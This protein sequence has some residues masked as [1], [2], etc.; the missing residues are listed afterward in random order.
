MV[1]ISN[2][3]TS[4]IKQC[5]QRKRRLGLKGH[6]NEETVIALRG[7]LIQEDT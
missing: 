3:T 2:K 1:F 5:V 7:A 6:L 4:N